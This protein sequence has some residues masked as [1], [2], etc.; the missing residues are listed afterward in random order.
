MTAPATSTLASR[1]AQMAKI[2]A[3]ETV[4]ANES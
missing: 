2:E 3:S 1:T 4:L